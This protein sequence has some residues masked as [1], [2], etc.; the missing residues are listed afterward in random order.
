[1][2]KKLKKEVNFDYSDLFI[3][4]N[5]YTIKLYLYISNTNVL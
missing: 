4:T 2:L 1:M 5:K 3:N